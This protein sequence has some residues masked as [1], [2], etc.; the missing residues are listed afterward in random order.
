MESQDELTNRIV[1]RKSQLLGWISNHAA[2]HAPKAIK[3]EPLPSYLKITTVPVTARAHSGLDLYRAD[4][5]NQH[6]AENARRELRDE[7]KRHGRAEPTSS[8]LLAHAN[9]AVADA[10]QKDPEAKAKYDEL[11]RQEKEATALQRQEAKVFSPSK[12]ETGTEVDSEVR[13][14]QLRDLDYSLQGVRQT[15]AV[16]TVATIVTIVG[17]LNETGQLEII[18]GASDPSGDD[19]FGLVDM[20]EHSRRPFV[21][22]FKECL[23]KIFPSAQDLAQPVQSEHESPS[24]AHTCSAPSSGSNTQPALVPH[25]PHRHSTPSMPTSVQRRYAGSAVTPL[26]LPQ[27]S[28]NLRPSRPNFA[29]VDPILDDDEV[30]VA[31][32]SQAA[33][34]ALPP[35]PRITDVNDDVTT[36]PPISNNVQAQGKNPPIL[37]TTGSI[38]DSEAVGGS[39]KSRKRKS[40]VLT[41]ITEPQQAPRRGGRERNFTVRYGQATPQTLE[42]PSAQTVSAPSERP[43][44]GKKKADKGNSQDV[45]KENPKGSNG[46]RGRK[47]KAKKGAV[48]VEEPLAEGAPVKKRRRTGK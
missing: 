18:W 29:P 47:A 15:Y 43:P 33:T 20:L 44:I 45:Q 37:E 13:K 30:L 21:D 36:P 5:R 23:L 34:M 35:T 31:S 19:N 16:Q 38:A 41:S 6:I 25:T 3:P 1:A 7:A 32:S 27:T 14:K 26:R 2:K 46:S 9:R 11:S 8:E 39:R 40:E 28:T 48:E 10:Y 17:T 12:D 24:A 4:P 42:S 22:E